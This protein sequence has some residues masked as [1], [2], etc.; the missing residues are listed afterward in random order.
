MKS[1]NDKANCINYFTNSDNI[2]TQQHYR[3]CRDYFINKLS[4]PQLT[5]KYGYASTSIYDIIKSFSDKLDNNQEPFFL[6]I[7]AGRKRTASFNDVIIMVVKLRNQ[8]LS[9]PE[10]KGQLDASGFNISE[11][12]VYAILDEANF[13]RL[14]K[15]DEKTRGE[16][17]S[18]SKISEIIS[19]RKS[20]QFIYEDDTF[21]SENAGILTFLPFIKQFH[22]DEAIINSSYPGTTEISKI[23]S[24]LS[25][26]ALKLSDIA[27]YNSDDLWRMDKGIGIFAGLTVLPNATWFNTYSS[28][29]TREDN[30][31]FLTSLSEIW[32]EA[33]LLSSAANLDFTTIP[34]WGN[35]ETFESDRSGKRGQAL[36]SMLAVLARDPETG[37]ICY[38][39]TPV[40]HTNSDQVILDFLDFYQSNCNNN[41]KYLTFECKFTTYSQLGVLDSKGIKFITIQRRGKNIIQEIRN[42]PES[43]WQDI[44]VTKGHNQRREVKACQRRTKLY[45]YG[46]RNHSHEIRQIFIHN[47]QGNKP[48]IIITNDFDLSI[49]SVVRKYALRWLVEEEIS[50]QFEFFHLN[51]L[52]SSIV[53]NVDFDLTMSILAYNLYMLIANHLPSFKQATINTINTRF[54]KNSA[55]ITIKDKNIIVKLNKNKMLPDILSIYKRLYQGSYT[56]IDNCSLVLSTSN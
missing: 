11:R 37:L 29:I 6:D 5:N 43:E 30:V 22:I 34:Y 27:R 4:V 13:P 15:R 10:I 40:K 12:T 1:N 55:N 44:I 35:A 41:I 33:G 19:A 3:L 48:A 49:E 56:W 46:D 25:F 14:N 39:D 28:G 18:N 17:P 47:G 7:K 51:R 23:S 21:H 36:A 16:A 24:I 54:I 32:S 52:S 20:E 9:V 45:A 31:K 38:G 2:I 26:L 8:N 50:E 42:I 53:V